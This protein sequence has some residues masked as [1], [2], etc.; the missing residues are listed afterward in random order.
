MLKIHEIPILLSQM[1]SLPIHPACV[2]LDYRMAFILEL[3]HLRALTHTST[4]KCIPSPHSH[5]TTPGVCVLS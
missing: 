1:F 2:L 4:H 5:T 3:V